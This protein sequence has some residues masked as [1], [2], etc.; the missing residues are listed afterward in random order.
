MRKPLGRMDF[1]SAVIP[2]GTSNGTTNAVVFGVA[3][4]ANR[5]AT[6][7]VSPQPSAGD[8]APRSRCARLVE[9]S[10]RKI[11]LQRRLRG[12]GSSP[13][14]AVHADS[15]ERARQIRR[16]GDAIFSE[17]YAWLESLEPPRYPFEIDRSLAKRGEAVFNDHCADCHGTLWRRRQVIRTRSS[18]SRKSAPIRA[19][20]ARSTE[21]S[22]CVYGKSWFGHFGKNETDRRSGRL[23][24]A[25]AGRHLGFSPLFPQRLCAHA[26]AR[27]APR[28]ATR[29]VARSED[30]YDQEKVGLEV[31]SSERFPRTSAS[32]RERA[33]A[34]ST[35]R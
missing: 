5:D 12:E 28:R 16:V 4:M 10:R 34:T 35:L 13:A 20:A 24:G 6:L 25:A 8:G 22:P 21:R 30:G 32:G 31:Q 29:G 1:G 33:A 19:A 27:D 17:I 11:A 3:L 15:R 14:D 23:R 18:R 2:L 9:L 7:N 26:V